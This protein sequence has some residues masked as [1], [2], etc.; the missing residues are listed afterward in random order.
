M[1][2]LGMDVSAIAQELKF[3][4]FKYAR[5]L[6]SSPKQLARGFPISKM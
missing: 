2:H 1:D 3:Q 5:E 6:L 4:K